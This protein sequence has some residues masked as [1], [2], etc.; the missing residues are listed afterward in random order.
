[1]NAEFAEKYR[2]ERR[3]KPLLRTERILSHPQLNRLFFC[4]LNFRLD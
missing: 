4:V 1:L 3:E 2:G